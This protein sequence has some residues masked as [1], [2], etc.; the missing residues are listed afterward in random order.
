LIEEERRRK[1]ILQAIDYIN[2]KYGDFKITWG[3]Y[4]QQRRNSGVISPAWRPSG[5]KNVEVK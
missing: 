2:D 1:Y 5:V 4:I 3:S